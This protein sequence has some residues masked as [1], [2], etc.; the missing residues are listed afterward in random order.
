MGVYYGRGDNLVVRTEELREVLMAFIEEHDAD[1][2][3][4]G[5]EAVAR[6][7]RGQTAVRGFTARNY[8][9]FYSGVSFRV[10]GRIL[11]VEQE[12]TTFTI[13]DMLLTAIDEGGRLALGGVDALWVGVDP[14]VGQG[15][16]WR[17]HGKSRRVET[18]Q[19]G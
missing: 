8:L 11:A 4:Q 16:P 2:P 9:N 13:A 3:P 7:Q 14:R 10:L 6:E 15:I 5:L 17:G 19:G 12:Y 18:A 1:H